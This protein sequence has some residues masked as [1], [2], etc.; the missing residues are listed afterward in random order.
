MHIYKTTN[1]I[2]GKIYIGK[3]KKND[4]S[5][6]GSGKLLGLAIKKYGKSQFIKEI[7]EECSPD[8]INRKETYWI[9]Y[10]QSTDRT[11]GYN[12]ALGGSGGDTISNHPDKVSIGRRHSKNLKGRDSQR[13]NKGPLSEETKKKISEKLSGK[14]NPMFGKT[15]SPETKEKIKISQIN[16]P[17]ESRICSDSTKRKIS[18]SNLGKVVSNETR[19]RQSIA[20][21]G[22]RNPFYGKTHTTENREIFRKNGSKPK[23]EDTKKKLSEANNGR[24]N[25]KQNKPFIA[26]TIIYHSLGQC[27]KLTNEP[28]HKIRDK[29]STGEYQYITY[30][31]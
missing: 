25:G 27:N 3:E 5:Y 19:H 2:N 10:F 4:P 18:E 11:I 20:K 31:I 17:K 8:C 29:L 21:L 30:P 6:L 9:D 15:H 14:N 7:I 22:N 24:Y 28:V 16:R 12:I 26:N 13:T 1:K 23:S